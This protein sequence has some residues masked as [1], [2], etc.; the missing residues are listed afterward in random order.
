[1]HLCLNWAQGLRAAEGLASRL[2]C[3]CHCLASRLL[4]CTFPVF[5]SFCVPLRRGEIKFGSRADERGNQYSSGVS[6]QW[7]WI[8]TSQW[9]QLARQVL[10]LISHSLILEDARLNDADSC[11]NKTCLHTETKE[12]KETGEIME[13]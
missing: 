4:S 8:S 13:F 6:L 7:L 9:A 12:D 10:P 3:N 5:P 1:M 11:A 2:L